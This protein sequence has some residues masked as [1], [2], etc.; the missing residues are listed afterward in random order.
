MAAS[1]KPNA[2]MVSASWMSEAAAGANLLLLYKHEIPGECARH[3][4]VARILLERGFDPVHLFEHRLTQASE[5]QEATDKWRRPGQS[6][7]GAAFPRQSNGVNLRREAMKNHEPVLADG[8][9]E[10]MEGE[11]YDH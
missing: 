1:A 10:E 5:L 7:S 3:N 4:I 6:H 8:R 11:P 2:K 9:V